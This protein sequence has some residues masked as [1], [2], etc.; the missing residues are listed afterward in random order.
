VSTNRF[1]YGVRVNVPGF[2]ADDDAF[3]V[4]PRRER[5]VALRRVGD[6]PGP[7][8]GFLTALNLAGRV[9]VASEVTS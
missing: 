2:V 1:A 7:A 8:G 5:H 9:A 6:A 4:E 3:S